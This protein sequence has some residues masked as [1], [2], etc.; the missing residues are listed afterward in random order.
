MSISFINFFIF[1]LKLS[2]SF[3][4]IL[5]SFSFK[6]EFNKELILKSPVK[7]IGPIRVSLS[8]IIYFIKLK[9]ISNCS[10]LTFIDLLLGI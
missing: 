4:I 5:F 3:L 6:F 9:I 7:I 8:L 2:N 10:S 1:L